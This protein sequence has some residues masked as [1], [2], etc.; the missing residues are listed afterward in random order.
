MSTKKQMVY[1]HA[2][3]YEKNDSLNYSIN[4]H[5][6]EDQGYVLIDEMEVEMVIPDHGD[7]KEVLK[8]RK[9]AAL[10]AQLEAMK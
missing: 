4:T 8:A 7:I 9:R 6:M 2:W 3:Y 5:N 10:E 1:L